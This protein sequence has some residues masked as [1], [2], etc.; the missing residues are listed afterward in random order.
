M[1]CALDHQ[2]E[3]RGE[4]ALSSWGMAKNGI[5]AAAH[6]QKEKKLPCC[7]CMLFIVVSN[8]PFLDSCMQNVLVIQGTKEKGA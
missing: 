7:P 1:A 8:I 4:P 2:N 5:I 6:D 3:Q